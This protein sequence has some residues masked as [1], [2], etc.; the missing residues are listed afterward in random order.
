ML[1]PGWST[2]V[3]S[4]PHLDVREGCRFILETY[5]HVPFW[6]QFPRADLREQMYLQFAE[7]FPRERIQ[8]GKGR[9]ILDANGDLSEDLA[10]F[11][12]K[13]LSQDVEAFSIG[14]GHARGLWT[15]LEL[16]DRERPDSLK[17]VKGQVTGPVSFG[18]AVTDHANR[19]IIFHD[20]LADAV[21]DGLAMRARWQ[22]R[23]L[24]KLGVPVLISVDEPYLVSLG[25]G[26]IPV[27]RERALAMLRRVVEA[28]RGEGCFVS[29]HCCGGTDWSLVMEAGP[30]LI[31]FDAFDYFET[32]ILYPRELQA[33]LR[34][35]GALAWG[36]VPS[37]DVMNSVSL[38][39]LREKWH[40]SVRALETRGVE[41]ALMTSSF[42]IT[43]SCGVG[44]LPI[45][46][47]ER[48]LRKAA[49]LSTMLHK[50]AG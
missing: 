13:V 24:A 6:P 45:D 41:K 8:P 17:M 42:L 43:T 3:G 12:E 29:V 27:E 19:S 9:L 5:P 1:F 20:Q 36:I 38:E 16:L 47:A 48:A 2:G 31:N 10:A 18:L 46:T 44:T 32:L 39:E 50:D 25:S 34:G 40:T 15:M 35:G 14:P 28:I 30:D 4:L 21:V 11:Y 23:M 33:F 7:G 49:R 37:S 26:Y 22:A